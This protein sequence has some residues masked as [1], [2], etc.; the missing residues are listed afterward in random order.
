MK[1]NLKEISGN[2]LLVD[3]EEEFMELTKI[4]L[5][6]LK[7]NWLIKSISDPLEALKYLKTSEIYDIIIS[8]Y[9]MP[10]M[11]G[12]ELLAELRNSNHQIPFI[13][14]TGKGREEVAIEA[15]N[16]GANYYIK[17]GL[18]I[19][20]QYRELIHVMETIIDH[21]KVEKA[22]KQSQQR[23]RILINQLPLA[24]EIFKPNGEL[25][26]VNKA[27]ELLWNIKESDV[28]GNYNVLENPHI[29]KMGMLPKVKELF[30]GSREILEFPALEFDPEQHGMLGR[31][32]WI[33]SKGYSVFD[34]NNEVVNVITIT[35]DITEL[36]E[37]QEKAKLQS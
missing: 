16:L 21:K 17:K 7:K 15:L 32:R 34:E 2:I 4:Y 22:L 3:D 20:S 35:Y 6:K 33:Q 23:Y 1:H 9:Q 30:K 11:T 24:I 25:L 28:V 26:N 10:R 8:D 5:N 18:D 19:K 14:F 37:L 31:K 12:I 29:Q 27:F 13:V 36:K